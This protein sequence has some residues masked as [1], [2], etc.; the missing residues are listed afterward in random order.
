M[1]LYMN[2]TCSLLYAI[3]CTRLSKVPV[4]TSH[5]YRRITRV[6]YLRIGTRAS[7]CLRTIW[8]NIIYTC[9][10]LVASC[11]PASCEFTPDVW[12]DSPSKQMPCRLVLRRTSRCNHD[13]IFLV[14]SNLFRFYPSA[15]ENYAPRPR[16][17]WLK[18]KKD[19]A[20]GNKSAVSSF[21]KRP[22]LLYLTYDPAAVSN[23][24]SKRLTKLVNE[25]EPTLNNARNFS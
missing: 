10:P 4:Y 6:P 22:R 15:S 7:S 1:Y 20:E 24:T 23:I 19:R 17:S 25:I 14:L 13:E 9:V 21:C 11:L 5:V 18:I 12:R 3:I 2:V 16:F 8:T